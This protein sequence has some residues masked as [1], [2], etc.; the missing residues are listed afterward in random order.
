MLYLF[1]V[2]LPALAHH[3]IP[4]I[5]VMKPRCNSRYWFCILFTFLFYF[6]PAQEI[7]HALGGLH[8]LVS[9]FLLLLAGIIADLV[10]L[11]KFLEDKSRDARYLLLFVSGV[12][13]LWALFFAILRTDTSNAYASMSIGIALAV[14]LFMILS[15]KPDTKDSR[16]KKQAATVNTVIVVVFF[17]AILGAFVI[18]SFRS[19]EVIKARQREADQQV[20]EAERKAAAQTVKARLHK[21][22]GR[23]REDAYEPRMTATY[24]GETYTIS[25]L[26][27]QAQVM[28]RKQQTSLPRIGDG[29]FWGRQKVLVC[30]LLNLQ[31]LQDLK[32]QLDAG[33][34]IS[35]EEID[36][37]INVSYPLTLPDFI[38]ISYDPV[39]KE[40][41]YGLVMR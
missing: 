7:G 30:R 36:G 20:L 5:Y 32:R 37:G 4:Y 14:Q 34:K 40:M 28:L 8:Y 19:S 6:C 1:N 38:T 39:R 11:S 26:N 33:R 41:K 18:R 12:G 25:I 17:L 3:Q 21:V 27:A 15:V 13:S 29:L 10:L 22:F 24:L 31:Q 9:M 35:Y 16:E 2:K 23:I